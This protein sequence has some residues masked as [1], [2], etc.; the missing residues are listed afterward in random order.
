LIRERLGKQLH[1]LWFN[2]HGTVP[3]VQMPQISSLHEVLN[4]LE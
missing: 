4:H 3:K 2:P 1:S